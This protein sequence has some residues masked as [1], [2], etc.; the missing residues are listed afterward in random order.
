LVSKLR[1]LGVNDAQSAVDGARS[2][3]V[4]ESEIARLIEVWRG[5]PNAWSAGALHYRI[6]HARPRE[7]AGKGWPVPNK[8]ADDSAK[9]R[10][11]SEESRRATRRYEI[12]RDGRSQKKTDDA[13]TAE[14]AAEGLTWE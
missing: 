14:L 8:A 10:Q 12:I 13:I 6:V 5:H 3:G 1:S 11:A 9:K 2:R 7:D 4:T